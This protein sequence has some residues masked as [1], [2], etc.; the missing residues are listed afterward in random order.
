MSPRFSIVIPT[1]NRSASVLDTLQSC[2]EQTFDDFEVVVVDDGSS[3][4]TRDV[5]AAIDDPRLRVLHQDNAGPAAARNHGMKVAAGQYIAFLDSDDRWYPTFL[6]VA[7]D[8]LEEDEDVLLY[9]QIIVDRGVD[10]YWVKPA[11]ALGAEESIFDYL[12]VDGSFIQTST[13]VMPRTLATRVQWDES[14]TFGDNDQFAID[15]WRTGIAFRMLPQPLTLYA[16]VISDEALSQLPIH[17]GTSEKYTNFFRWMDTQK[18]AM[19]PMAWAGFQARFASV[20]LA[21]SAPVRSFGLLWKA[22]RTGAMGPLGMVRQSVQNL[23]P[24]LYRRLVDQYVRYR[25][26]TLEQARRQ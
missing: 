8:C 26:L 10:R 3:D 13:M 7:N 23:F 2:F 6:Q 25:G 9:G 12:Y 15:C 4:D 19:S 16:D 11:R 22:Y 20:G 17:A 14:V 1:Y 21:R 18:T 24:R 5:L